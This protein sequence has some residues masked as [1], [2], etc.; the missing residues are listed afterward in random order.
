[1]I[2]DSEAIDAGNDN[3]SAAAT[4]KVQE[5]LDRARAAIDE[6]QQINALGEFV[7]HASTLAQVITARK[8]IND[9]YFLLSTMKRPP[10]RTYEA[11]EQ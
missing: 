5:I 7:D 11:I 6:A 4:A 1:M 10:Q 2:T 8:A 9:A 3:D